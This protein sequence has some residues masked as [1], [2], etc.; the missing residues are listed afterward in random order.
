M[1]VPGIVL[2]AICVIFLAAIIIDGGVSG[3]G[4][5]LWPLA[6]CLIVWVVFLR[7]CVRLTQSGVTLVNLVRDVRFGWPA[8]DLIEQRWN[9]KLYDEHGKGYGSWAITAQRPR[10]TPRRSGSGGA[11]GGLGGLGPG[12]GPI[13]PEDPGAVM[14]SRPGSAATVGSA[15]RD[16][17]LDYAGAAAR[18]ASYEAE[19]QVT[20]GPAWPAIGALALAVVCIVVSIVG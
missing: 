3:P 6:G 20:V 18:D 19:D 8:V 4:Q 1:L 15:I 16:G 2:G 13:D 10:R 11:L 5:I 14:Q 7:P 17:Q 9:L 12:L